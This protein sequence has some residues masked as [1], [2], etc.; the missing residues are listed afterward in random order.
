MN[1][2]GT[3]IDTT[4]LILLK[5]SVTNTRQKRNIRT[6]SMPG[7]VATKRRGRGSEID[8]IR[9]W[10]YGDDIRTID[11]NSTAR[12]GVPPLASGRS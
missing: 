10:T 9:L 6:Q 12:T 1:D 8:D 3:Y 11:R 7:P 4:A 5:H 2:K